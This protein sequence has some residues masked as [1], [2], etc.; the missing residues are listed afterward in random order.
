MPGPEWDAH[1]QANSSRRDL[2]WL[3]AGLLGLL[4][5]EFCGADLWLIRMYGT[6]QGFAW[7]HHL[8]MSRVLHDGGR[9]LAWLALAILAWDAW[10]QMW[11]GPCRRDRLLAI[12]L[13]LLATLAI[14][15][16]KRF[17][18][19]SCPWDLAEFGGHWPYVPHW[20]WPMRDGGPGHCFPSGHASSAFS[21]FLAWAI[22]RHFN[23]RMARIM[24]AASL[25]LGILFAW[26][27][28]ARGAHFLSHSM[29]TAWLCWAA[30][31]GV[32][33]ATLRRRSAAQVQAT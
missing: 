30:A 1:R 14:S 12:A 21:F 5:W 23:V 2:A 32:S 26:V 27:Q 16:L 19:T 4:V 20:W 18:M 7:Q 10:V 15:G 24:L 6:P 17:S 28:M 31:T 33:R 8:L 22:W 3:L 25:S 29:W 11:P 9:W 13:V